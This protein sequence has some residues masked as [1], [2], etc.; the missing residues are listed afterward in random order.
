MAS[1]LHVSPRGEAKWVRGPSGLGA[2]RAEEK[3]ASRLARAGVLE[4]YVE[5]G[6]Q[7][8]RSPG[9]RMACFDRRV[10][11]NAGWRHIRNPPLH[12]RRIMSRAA[13]ASAK[14]EVFTN[15]ETRDTKHGFLPAVPQAAV[16]PRPPRPPGFWV[17]RHETRD[18]AFLV[19]G[20]SQREFQGFHETRDTKHESRLFIETRLFFESPPW[21]PAHDCPPLPGIAHYCPA[22]PGPHGRRP[23]ALRQP[24]HRLPVCIAS[25]R[26]RP[27][28]PNKSPPT[29]NAARE[30]RP[31]R[32]P[33]FW[34]TRH[35]TRDTNHGFFLTKPISSPHVSSILRKSSV[36]LWLRHFSGFQVF[37]NSRQRSTAV[38]SPG[39]LG[40]ETR[41]TA[42]YARRA[43]QREFQGFHETRDTAYYRNTAFPRP[44]PHRASQ[45]GPTSA[46][47]EPRPPRPPRV[48][49][50]RNT[51][52]E[53]RDTA[54][55]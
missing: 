26:N 7:A 48:F 39:V 40:H 3:G 4:P 43:S 2:S 18:T 55:S 34:V 25:P 23:R 20:A 46:A 13:Q 38:P 1:S 21:F 22:P 30:P 6:K 47:L 28:P 51:N 14:S 19:R 9:A 52:H 41:G 10:V 37:A 17:T 45:P 11:R 54:F 33:G 5:H 29:A 42:F 31:R 8:Q 16:E 32:L 44:F 36:A 12:R 24:G 50:S 49:G 35:E 27:F 53:T 15:H